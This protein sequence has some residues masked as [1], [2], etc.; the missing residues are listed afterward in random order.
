M[1]AS[2]FPL[3]KVP[4][5]EGIAKIK[6]LQPLFIKWPEN[7]E[8]E[9][10][11]AFRVS[12]LKGN[13]WYFHQPETI[14]R[15]TW[16]YRRISDRTYPLKLVVLETGTRKEIRRSEKLICVKHVG[17]HVLSRHNGDLCSMTPLCLIIVDSC[18]VS[19][20]RRYPEDSNLLRSARGGHIV[21]DS[22][23]II[24]QKV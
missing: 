13:I 8:N 6:G 9:N 1:G 5:T 12:G 7:S 20:A 10:E 16:G 23:L 14:Y 2:P 21:V 24:C 11:S 17:G 19:V 22:G 15:I 3:V 18:F 4:F